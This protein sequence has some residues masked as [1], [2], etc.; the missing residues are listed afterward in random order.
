MFAIGRS[1]ITDIKLDSK[2]IKNIAISLRHY[3]RVPFPA[4]C[5]VFSDTK[6]FHLARN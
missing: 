5:D 6:E 3:S 4:T 1:V 2:E